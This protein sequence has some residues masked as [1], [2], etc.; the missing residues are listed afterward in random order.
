[1]LF[2]GTQFSNLYIAVDLP[3][4]SFIVGEVGRCV[5]C[6]G[7]LEAVW[8][9]LNGAHCSRCA[10]LQQCKSFA[11]MCIVSCLSASPAFVCR[12]GAAT[13]GC[14]RRCCS[15]CS[16]DSASPLDRTS[17]GWLS[18]GWLKCRQRTA[19]TQSCCG[20]G[21]P[22]RLLRPGARSGLPCPIPTCGRRCLL[23]G[24]GSGSHCGVEF[25]RSR[26]WWGSSGGRKKGVV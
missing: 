11:E 21:V 24:S 12:Q 20:R 14:P 26:N 8:H 5:G 15:L 18:F 19:S 7:G 17:G 10:G 16:R 23:A 9:P 6:G 22:A 4:Q 2:I 25:G 1:V 13:W 3:E